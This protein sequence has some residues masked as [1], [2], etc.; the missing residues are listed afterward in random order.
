LVGP[1][2]ANAMLVSAEDAYVGL[3]LPAA[4]SFP[5]AFNEAALGPPQSTVE[6]S[7]NGSLQVFPSMPDVLPEQIEEPG[8]LPAP[9]VRTYVYDGSRACV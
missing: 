8:G 2:A 9:T 7:E 3:H 4:Q 5:T 6:S 1:V